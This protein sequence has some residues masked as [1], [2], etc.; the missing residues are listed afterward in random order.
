[1]GGKIII[2]YFLQLLVEPKEHSRMQYLYKYS[3]CWFVESYL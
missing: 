3:T 2:P 1:M